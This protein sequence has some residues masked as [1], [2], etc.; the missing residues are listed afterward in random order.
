MLSSYMDYIVVCYF[1]LDLN[2]MLVKI[3]MSITFF[4]NFISSIRNSFSANLFCKGGGANIICLY[5]LH[6]PLLLV[7]V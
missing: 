2:R 4:F 1:I 5:F 7:S 6:G 3:Q